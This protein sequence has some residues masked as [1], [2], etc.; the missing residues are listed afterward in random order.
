MSLKLIQQVVEEEKIQY[1][2][3]GEQSPG[4]KKFPEL[5]EA[6]SKAA[7]EFDYLFIKL[8]WSSPKVFLV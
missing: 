3:E 1:N 8:N 6:V 7:D 4:K 2:E 5:E